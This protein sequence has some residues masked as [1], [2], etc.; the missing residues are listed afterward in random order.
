MIEIEFLD[1]ARQE[2]RHAA[3]YY[4]RQVAGLGF[5]FTDE[6]ERT[7]EL[8][9]KSPGVGSPVWQHYRRVF[10]RRFPYSVVYREFENKL[11]VVAVAHHRRRPNYWRVRA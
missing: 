6:V 8:I 11:I 2:L 9:Q 7:V 1:D 5:A 10:V 3:Q 4:E